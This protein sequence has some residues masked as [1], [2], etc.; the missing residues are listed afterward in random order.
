[1]V[2]SETYLGHPLG[3]WPAADKL[4]RIIDTCNLIIEKFLHQLAAQTPSGLPLCLAVPAWRAPNGQLHRL[5]LLD[6][7]SKLGYNRVSFEH[8]REPE[9]VYFR[10]DQL[11][12]RELLVI[13]RN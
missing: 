11:V 13:I 12:A 1:A 2:A 8:V 10:P 7:L 5:P 9:L 3:S 6:H 4:Q